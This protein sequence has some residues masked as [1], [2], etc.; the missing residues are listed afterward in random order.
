MRTPIVGIGFPITPVTQPDPLTILENQ[1]NQR[2]GNRVQS[3]Q[4][5]LTEEGLIIQGRATTYHAKQ[6]V[7]HTIMECSDLPIVRNE[8]EVL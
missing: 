7:Q 5:M 8:I 2:V 3:L 4:L 6:I 1:I